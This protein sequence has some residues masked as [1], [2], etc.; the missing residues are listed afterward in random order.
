M[1][2]IF[3]EPAAL[4][5]HPDLFK[6]AAARHVDVQEGVAGQRTL[7]DFAGHAGGDF[8][9]RP[10]VVGWFP[11]YRDG[12]R[13]NSVH[14]SFDR[15]RHGSRVGDIIAEVGAGVYARDQEV[16]ANP[17]NFLQPDG[18]A[19]GGG[20]VEGVDVRPEVDH[21]ERPVHGEGMG[22]RRIIAIGG[23]DDGSA[24]SA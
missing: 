16:R 11:A 21:L 14:G 13:R 23:D 5:G 19:V 4:P 7:Q 20:A 18:D 3:P 12:H 22:D 8:H 24:E 17:K 1:D 6:A 9:G 15:R 10:I 2:G